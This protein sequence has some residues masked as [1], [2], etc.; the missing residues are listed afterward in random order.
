MKSSTSKCSEAQT[1]GKTT[2]GVLHPLLSS[3]VQQ[4]HKTYWS[5]PRRGPL[6]YVDIGASDIHE[7]GWESWACSSSSRKGLGGLINAHSWLTGGCTKDG[8]KVFSVLPTKRTR[9]N[10]YKLELRSIFELGVVKHRIKLSREVAEFPSLRILETQLDKDLSNLLCLI[11]LP[12]GE[13]NKTSRSNSFPSQLFCGYRFRL[14]SEPLPGFHWSP[15]GYSQLQLA[16]AVLCSVCR[17]ESSLKIL[18][19]KQKVQFLAVIRLLMSI[20]SS[21]HRALV[22][23]SSQRPQPFSQEYPEK[24]LGRV[25]EKKEAE[26]EAPHWPNEP[27]E[28]LVTFFMLKFTAWNTTL[29]KANGRNPFM[30]HSLPLK[31]F[32]LILCYSETAD[33][34]SAPTVLS[35]LNVTVIITMITTEVCHIA[36]C[37]SS[38]TKTDS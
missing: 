20:Q 23:H 9:S 7:R 27:P 21:I 25:K 37:K 30:L 34:T 22:I 5:S 28:H 35:L 12:A 2:P 3:A 33:L 15:L 11:L 18:Q 4:N 26:R 1:C 32:L 24:T 17:M 38:K 36:S 13:F 31:T 6:R 8:A 14:V 29:A 19:Q 16:A 10:R